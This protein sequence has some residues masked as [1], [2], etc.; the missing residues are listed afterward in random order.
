MPSTL[1]SGSTQVQESATAAYWKLLVSVVG[2]FLITLW[3]L[4]DGIYQ[5][6]ISDLWTFLTTASTSSEY[7]VFWELRLPRTLIA[8]I[9][10]ASLAIAGHLMQDIVKNPL[11]S[12]NLTGVMSGASLAV[13]IAM[14]YALPLP[15]I[16]WGVIG[17]FIGGITT[18]SISW[19][20]GVTP[21]RL[22]LAGISVSAF[23]QAAVT[24][25]L[26]SDR[27]DSESLFFWLTGSNAGANWNVLWPLVM[28]FVPISI[29]LLICQRQ[30]GYLLLD[31]TVARSVGVAI[32]HYRLAFGL[33]AVI[34]TAASV[35][36]F[37]PV[38]FVGLVAP[39]IARML[40]GNIVISAVIGASLL[41]VADYFSRTLLSPLE[42]PIGVLTAAMGA[43]WFLYLIINRARV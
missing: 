23:C 35:G 26:L 12:P 16:A 8:I 6:S 10:G 38:G 36:A 19:K 42:I 30:L 7:L 20:Q 14:M 18:L 22:A 33:L 37:G 2:F 5:Y 9:G 39:H 3:S 1:T 27:V 17:G 11:A 43:P 28:A 13:L 25:I 31:D 21:A 34:L 4:T 15:M 24:Y 40:R 32:N 41:T 29:L